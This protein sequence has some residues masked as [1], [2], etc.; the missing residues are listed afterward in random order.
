M[1]RKSLL[2]IILFL[3]SGFFL[4]GHG[5]RYEIITGE[6]VG[7]KAMFDDGTPMAKAPVL[8]FPPGE[9]EASLRLMTDKQGIVCFYAETPGT[10]ILQVRDSGGHGMRINYE[11]HAGDTSSGESAGG[12]D[13]SPVQKW[14][15]GIAVLW[16]FVG[17]ALYFKQRRR[18]ER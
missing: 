13:F 5:T 6:I 1:I 4:Y 17:T 3:V 18:K 12:G 2:V 15:M 11:A 10:W 9:S 7:V 16:G 14:I 8:V